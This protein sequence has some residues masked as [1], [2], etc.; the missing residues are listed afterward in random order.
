MYEDK[1]QFIIV[2]IKIKK[3]IN[4]FFYN[5]I[6]IYILF[7]MSSNFAFSFF[8]YLSKTPKNIDLVKYCNF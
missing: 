6:E 5:L 8:S 2:I 4:S 3:K 7:V 1:P